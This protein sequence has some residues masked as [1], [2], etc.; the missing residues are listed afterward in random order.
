MAYGQEVISCQGE[1][2]SNASGSIEF[3]I[4][5]VI[6]ATETDGSNSLTQGFHQT[7]W[8][9]VGLENHYGNLEAIIYP[10]PMNTD[11][12]IKSENFDGVS[13]MMYN[14]TG[15]IVVEGMLVSHESSID[16]EKFAKGSY[17]LVLFK[18]DK[19]MKTFKLI[20]QH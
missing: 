18:E 9:F 5:E 4:G 10:N 20:K 14:A 6:I 2:Y 3:T 16:V 19:K 11:L 15:K 8:N 1:S 12:T 13:Y 7:N 17:N